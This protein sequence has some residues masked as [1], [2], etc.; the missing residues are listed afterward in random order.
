MPTNHVMQINPEFFYGFTR[1]LEGAL[2][3]PVAISPNGDSFLNGLRLR[4]KYIASRQPDEATFYGMNVELGRDSIRTSE[5]SST[6][7]VRPII[8]YRD[9]KWLLS[10]NPI[11]NM[12]LS[13]NVSHQP[14]FEPALKMARSVAEDVRVGLEYYGEYGALNALWPSDQRSHTLYAVI[15]V[16]THD[17]EVNFGLGRGYVNAADEWVAKAI[18]ALPFEK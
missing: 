1:N 2:Y 17:L 14:Q 4:L 16:E 7:E 10:F 6:F 18:I 12:G 15:D 11:F 13:D 5:S 8:G 3:V 9:A